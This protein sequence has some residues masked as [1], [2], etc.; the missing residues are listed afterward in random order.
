MK[1]TYLLKRKKREKCGRQ[2]RQQISFSSTRHRCAFSI[3]M[4]VMCVLSLHSLHF[5]HFCGGLP[6]IHYNKEYSFWERKRL[7]SRLN[8]AGLAPGSLD[9]ER[10]ARPSRLTLKNAVPFATLCNCKSLWGAKILP[11]APR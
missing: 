8:I 11:S 5:Y 2:S 10:I 9:A 7:R 6:F 3:C 4:C 1:Q